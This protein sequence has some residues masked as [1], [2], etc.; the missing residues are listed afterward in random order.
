VIGEI[1]LLALA[2]AVNPTMLGVVVVLLALPGRRSLIAGYLIGGFVVSVGF[3]LAVLGGV[4]GSGLL[5]KKPHISPLIDLIAGIVVLILV[6]LLAIRFER[7]PRPT[8][9][10]PKPPG[11]T[12]RMLNRGTRSVAL[13]V[14]AV[15]NLPGVYYIVALKDAAEADYGT[16]ARI[17]VVV[18]FN[19]VMFLPAIVPLV[20]L[21]VRPD[22]TEAHIK[23]F[24]TR[25]GHLTHRYGRPAALFVGGG[26][27]VYLVLRGALRL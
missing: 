15:T 9:D 16:G 7:H 6:A 24:T 19:V 17:A 3:G 27:G 10:T 8:F 22:S 18:G 25:L 26:I 11:R 13:V 21:A 1:L 2:S 23:R 12:A 5:E 20:M 14:G 4:V